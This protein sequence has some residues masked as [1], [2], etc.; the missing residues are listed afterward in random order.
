MSW[1]ILNECLRHASR[2]VRFWD[3]SNGPLQRNVPYRLNP[4]LFKLFE[5]VAL[6]N[7]VFLRGLFNAEVLRSDKGLG[8]N[9]FLVRRRDEALIDLLNKTLDLIGL[10]LAASESLSF[11]FLNKACCMMFLF[12]Y[13]SR[14]VEAS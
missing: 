14:F 5:L 12:V 3:Q 13:L 1:G 8:I 2:E 10:E 4:H 6:S 9:C 7:R 11:V